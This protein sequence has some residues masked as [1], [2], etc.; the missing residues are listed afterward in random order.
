MRGQHISNLY[1]YNYISSS[2]DCLNAAKSSQTFPIESHTLLVHFE[3]F[4]SSSLPPFL[5]R[6]RSLLN[7]IFSWSGVVDKRSMKKEF[8]YSSRDSLTPRDSNATLFWLGVM[9]Y[10]YTTKYYFFTE[11]SVSQLISLLKKRWLCHQISLR[12]RQNFR[13]F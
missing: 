1:L 7:W 13:N 8:T 2:K 5:F 3:F 11:S 6:A 12:V 4:F 9:S 10:D